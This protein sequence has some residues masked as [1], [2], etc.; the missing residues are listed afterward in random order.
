M[1]LLHITC[2][3]GL[4]LGVKVDFVDGP[5]VSKKEIVS[6]IEKL[7]PS[8]IFLNGHGDS[9]IFYGYDGKEAIGICDADMFK[10]KIVFARACNCIE[11]LGR[12]AVKKH[13][14]TSFIGYEFEFVNVR[15]T[16]VELKPRED[17]ISRPIWEVSNTVPI[18]LMKIST[19]DE[20][21]ET[22]HKKTTKEISKLL[23]SKELG[24]TSVLKA[25]I[26]NDEGLKY[27]GD[28]SA[29]I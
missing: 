29:K 9:K 28:G 2:T 13:S 24:A 1:I 18:K 27:Y 14:C 10:D 7:N 19:A 26:I 23:F 3:N 21:I 6:R 20:A 11:K 22:S 16:D 5:K 17:E 25:M 15:Q 4:F 12:E 8:F